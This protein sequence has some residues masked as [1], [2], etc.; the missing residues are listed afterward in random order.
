MNNKLPDPDLTSE[1]KAKVRLLSK[2]QIE[3]IDK[4][5]ISV[6]TNQWQKVAK[7]VGMTM[8][9]IP[10]RVKGIPDLYMVFLIRKVIYNL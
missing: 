8:L 3:E 5:I 1:E 6:A 9:N 7:I 4:A 2:K 10:S